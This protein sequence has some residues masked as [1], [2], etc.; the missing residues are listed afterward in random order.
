MTWRLA[1]SAPGAERRVSAR[2]DRHGL[3]H[4]YFKIVDRCVLRGRA[5]T[6]AI[7]LFPRYIFAWCQGSA[8]YEFQKIYEIV[9]IVPGV[10]AQVE[11]DK[12][13]VRAQGGDTIV[14]PPQAMEERFLPGER[15]RV[16]AGPYQGFD[17]IWH[18]RT[19]EQRV[20]VL[21]GMMG[22]Q[23]PIDLDDSILEPAPE[24]KARME[25]VWIEGRGWVE[26]PKVRKYR[27]RR[28]HRSVELATQAS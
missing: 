16:N 23:V 14:P 4:H 15:V 22:R 24:R 20:R 9:G 21:L 18:C 6:R 26:R 12:L 5:V 17:A 8:L 7:P 13:L 25:S 3:P 28:R 11:V 1:V 10:V 19:G 27:P 2:L